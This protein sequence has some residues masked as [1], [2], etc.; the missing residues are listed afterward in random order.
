[1]AQEHEQVQYR[2]RLARML[3]TGEAVELRQRVGMSQKELAR[4]LQV[5]NTSVNRWETG[6]GVPRDVRV[7]VRWINFLDLIARELD[8]L[9]EAPPYGRPAARLRPNARSRPDA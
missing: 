1:M 5:D 9:D 3:G 7:V 4:K 2:A 6:K 8:R